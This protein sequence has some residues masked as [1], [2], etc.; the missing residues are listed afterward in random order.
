MDDV[1]STAGLWSA[2]ALGAVRLLGWA[3]GKV[4]RRRLP[5]P[6]PAPRPAL[7]LMA[8]SPVAG[9]TVVVRWPDGSTLTVTGTPTTDRTHQ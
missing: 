7:P 8:C 6:D 4:R 2:V 5:I 9:T 1:T 3:V